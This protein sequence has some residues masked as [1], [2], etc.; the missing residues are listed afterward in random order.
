MQSFALLLF[1]TLLFAS[2][3]LIMAISSVSPSGPRAIIVSATIYLLY[4]PSLSSLKSKGIPSSAI[5]DPKFPIDRHAAALTL[6]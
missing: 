1:K 3:F 6:Q 5:C 2:F 4:Y